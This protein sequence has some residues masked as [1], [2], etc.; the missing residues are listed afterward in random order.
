MVN[1]IKTL[2]QLYKIIKFTKQG[3]LI[4]SY[5]KSTI[6]FTKQGDLIINAARHTVHNR[7]LFFD[8]CDQSF[9]NEA[10][11][12]NNKSKKHLEK[13]V[14]KNNRAQ[15]FTCE[16]TNTNIQKVVINGNGN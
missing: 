11:A 8:G 14:M 16:S 9:I 5:N 1:L 7:D 15:E 6:K 13:F 2:F 4:I 10:I 12:N 3:D